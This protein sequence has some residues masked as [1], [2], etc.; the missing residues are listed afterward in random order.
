[1]Y[2]WE[3]IVDRPR[4]P[5]SLRRGVHSKNR[6]D[7]FEAQ[8]FCF[9]ISKYLN[10]FV[11]GKYLKKYSNF[12]FLNYINFLNATTTPPPPDRIHVPTSHMYITTI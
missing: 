10:I 9:I 11:Q 12:N 2:F 8:L 6:F 5:F 4:L 3:F 7:R 1:M